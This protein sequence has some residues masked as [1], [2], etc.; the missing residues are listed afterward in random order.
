MDR[1]AG[2]MN[3]FWDAPTRSVLV[4]GTLMSPEQALAELK[5][6]K[7][8]PKSDRYRQLRDV[9]DGSTLLGGDRRFDNIFASKDVRIESA[10]IDQTTRA[11]DHQPAMATIRWD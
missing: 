7:L 10:L 1:L 9:A 4:D 8:D 3:T 11:S 2:S 6:G 5:T